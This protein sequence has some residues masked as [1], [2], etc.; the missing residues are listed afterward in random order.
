MD[1]SSAGQTGDGIAGGADGTEVTVTS[2]AGC[3]VLMTGSLATGALA[4][5]ALAAGALAAGALATGA[6]ATGSLAS[7]LLAASLL[8]GKKFQHAKKMFF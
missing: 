6:L 5:G 2:S 8:E 3:V 1:L 4:A 7:V